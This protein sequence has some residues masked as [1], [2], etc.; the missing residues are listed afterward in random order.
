M[1]FGAH[2]PT[3]TYT[4]ASHLFSAIG[5]N[6]PT[7]HTQCAG[8]SRNLKWPATRWGDRLTRQWG[9]LLR[10]L[11]PSACANPAAAGESIVN[12]IRGKQT[13][14]KSRRHQGMVGRNMLSNWLSKG[15]I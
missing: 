8:A 15:A 11:Q 6:D 3:L 5:R 7:S 14:E 1:L 4:S 2:H 13:A 12:R 9:A 10:L